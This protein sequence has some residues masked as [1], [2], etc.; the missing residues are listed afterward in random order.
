MPKVANTI[1]DA[2]RDVL[3][4][5]MSAFTVQQIRELLREQHLSIGGTKD[6]L[7]SRLDGALSDGAVA[8][9]EV[10]G[11]LDRVVPWWKFHAFLYSAPKQTPAHWRTEPAVRR[12]LRQHGVE[13]LMNAHVPLILPVQMTLASIEFSQ[14]RLRVTAIQRRDYTVHDADL[15]EDGENDEGQRVEWRAFVHQIARGMIVFE[16]DFLARTAFIQISELPSGSKYEDV[17]NQFVQLIRPWLN[18]QG[19]GILDVSLAIANLHEHEENDTPIARS[20]GIEYRTFAGRRLAGKSSAKSESVLGEEV[21]DESLRR[22]REEGIGHLGNFYWLPAADGEDIP[23]NVLESE[24]H[25]IIVAEKKRLNL[26]TRT[27]TDT[28]ESEMR[29]VLS[30]LRDLSQ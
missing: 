6:E 27:T 21:V 10:V 20:H 8:A 29:Y 5:A 26:R 2:E 7:I 11:L 14:D 25:V 28:T 17:R 22:I 30:R 12:H 4:Q 16:W 23:E 18:F 24:I 1:S 19:F 13:N 9:G 15:D 3:I